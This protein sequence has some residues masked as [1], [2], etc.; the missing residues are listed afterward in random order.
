VSARSSTVT[1]G[2]VAGET[3]RNAAWV[4]ERIELSRLV[5]ICADANRLARGSAPV[6]LARA[7]RGT[8]LTTARPTPR[9]AIVTDPYE[10]D[11][12]LTEEDEPLNEEDDRVPE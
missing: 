7:S 11:D 8:P 10:E 12:P 4:A 6:S 2:Q 1:G 5:R 9:K 3:C